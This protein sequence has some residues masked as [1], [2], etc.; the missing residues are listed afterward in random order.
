MTKRAEFT[1]EEWTLLRVTP[2]FVAVGVSAAD[3]SGLFSSIREA[4]AG[5]REVMVTLNA[6]KGI[7]LFSE[8]A[9]DRSAPKL[10]D[11]DALL[12]EGSN[13]QQMERFKS[14]ALERVR[15]TM[16]LVR[17]K[18]SAAE[19][20]AYRDLLLRVAERAAHASKEGS[21]LGIGGVRVSDKERAFIDLVRKAASE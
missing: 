16:A 13:E 8:I 4:L 3:A 21:F 2:S 15:Q 7:E 20:E 6:K 17:H 18:T 1:P 5:A 12:G 19:G 9:A 11:V 14:A 10:P